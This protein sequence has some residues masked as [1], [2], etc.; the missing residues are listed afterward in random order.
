MAS[1]IGKVVKYHIETKHDF[2][3]HSR[4]LGFMDWNNQPNPFRRFEG[5]ELIAL[6]VLE[7]KSEPISPIY[8]D[9]YRFATVPTVRMSSASISRFMELSLGLTAW[10]KAGTTLWPLR[11]NP[12]SGNLHPTEG[13]IVLPKIDENIPCGLYHYAP[14]EHGLEK[15]AH[16][17][18]EH[19]GALLSA[20]PPDA[21]LFGLTSIFWRESWK[22]GERAYRYA[23]T[24]I[25]HAL[26][27][28]RLAAATLGWKLV[29]LDD[30]SQTSVA[31]I[32]GVDKTEDFPSNERECPNFIAVC[33]PF[34]SV[35]LSPP[36]VPRDIP[37]FLDPAAI[38]VMLSS[39]VY[40]GKANRL[41]RRH[42]VEWQLIAEAAEHSWKNDGNTRTVQLLGAG[43]GARADV[44]NI[45]HQ[46]AEGTVF[47][48]PS[49]TSAS[50]AAAALS[51]P[52]STEDKAVVPADCD[53]GTVAV[54]EEED[55]SE[56]MA[57]DIIRQRRSAL[58]L[59]PSR[60]LP[61][62]SFFKIIER[63][64]V[65]GYG[66]VEPNF[67]SS[68]SGA[69]VD[70]PLFKRTVPFD[71]WPYAPA[72]HSIFLVHRVDGVVPG[73]YCLV[74]NTKR[75][76]FLQQTMDLDFE[77][78]PVPNCPEHVG[79]FLLRA[80]D[81]TELAMKLSCSQEIA[82]DGAFCVC[83]ITEFDSQLQEK[84]SWWYN[85]AYW[86]AGMCGQLIYLEAEAA[87]VRACGV[88]C[89][90]DDPLHKV[91]G[92]EGRALQCIYNQT[93]GYP[94]EDR[95]ILS[96]PPYMYLKHN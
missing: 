82:G 48:L 47:S 65:P 87:H 85:R 73:I 55:D 29:V 70:S 9:M 86:E 62:D 17:S 91:L 52:T 63:L 13:Y 26:A 23:E 27:C 38:D 10:K 22:Y 94:L 57:A 42:E 6:P 83:H 51:G 37:L 61:A 34:D 32:L 8:D 19:L 18:E 36:A 3:H 96:L 49:S 30:L 5:A 84:G 60:E 21:F 40:S 69:Q 77:W 31:A 43:T 74:R 93:V 14:K 88:G 58:M 2:N 24:D 15:R 90:Y 71:S 11:S 53:D 25:G 20:Y 50:C 54:E 56:P 39:A 33:F 78:S 59:D 12:S 44:E 81:F 68:S 67:S 46:I 95:R 79:L 7:A 80:G 4:S 89:F 64:V 1:G 35:T 16:L 28:A 66:D 76:I 41:S 75:L 92:I 72:L 45:T